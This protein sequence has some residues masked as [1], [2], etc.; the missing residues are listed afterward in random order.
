[1]WNKDVVSDS[2]RGLINNLYPLVEHGVCEDVF[3]E[4]IPSLRLQGREDIALGGLANLDRVALD[5]K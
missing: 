2:K 4:G 5:H 3:L 1:M